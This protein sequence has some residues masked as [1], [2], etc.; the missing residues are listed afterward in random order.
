MEQYKSIIFFRSLFQLLS[1]CPFHSKMLIILMALMFM[2]SCSEES[3]SSYEDTF[4]G[5]DS[6][7]DIIKGEK[8]TGSDMDILTY[9]LSSS[10]VSDIQTIPN[11]AEVVEDIALNDSFIKDVIYDGSDTDSEITYDVLVDSG[12]NDVTADYW[13]DVGFDTGYDSGTNPSLRCSG[14][15][16]CPDNMVCYLSTGIC[17]RRDIWKSSSDKFTIYNARPVGVSK[18]DV[19]V[20]D[21]RRFYYSLFGAMKVKISIGSTQKTADSYVDENRILVFIN[22]NESGNISITGEDGAGSYPYAVS[23]IKSDEIPCG[24]DDPPASGRE[25]PSIDSA[26]PYAAGYLDLDG[27]QTRV[28]YPALCGGLRRPAQKGTFPVIA[29]LHGDGA[30]YLNYEYLG[31]FLAS[32]GF[33]T[34]MPATVDMN[35]LTAIISAFINADLG[36]LSTILSGVRTTDK[37]GF[38]GH[39][40]GAERTGQVLNGS[41]L[42]LQKTVGCAFL[43]PVGLDYVVPGFFMIFYAT[44]DLQSSDGYSETYYRRQTAPK[45]YITIN[46][47]NH[48]LFTDHK[49]WAGAM[50]DGQPKIS[51]ETQFRVVTSFILPFF[52]KAFGIKEHFNE[53]LIN[54]PQSN[55]YTV[56][57]ELK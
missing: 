11:D 17:E 5:N 16:M 19:L 10:D 37:I 28:I 24:A 55:I 22:G 48:S 33:V 14:W 36:S 41:S 2:Y 50:M 21:G 1:E 3:P 46:G 40:R 45:W 6:E 4:E 18:G 39:S 53:Q 56:E 35:E 12:Y 29:I 38:V 32:W 31:Q 57:K 43:G 42:L 7:A 26:G 25:G 15:G 13:T 47:G 30:V 20:I 52:E 51:R 44:E 9:E 27:K 8:D 54:P 23:Q 34:F 49:V